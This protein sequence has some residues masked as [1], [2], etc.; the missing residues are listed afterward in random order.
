MYLL[1]Y[2]IIIFSYISSE[3]MDTF[4]KKIK[5]LKNSSERERIESIEAMKS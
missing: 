4:E 2:F 3:N 1:N 5:E